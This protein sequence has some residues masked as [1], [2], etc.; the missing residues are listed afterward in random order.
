M[1]TPRLII[2]PQKI[3]TK[4][5]WDCSG[6][7]HD[8]VLAFRHLAVVQLL[9]Q[10]FLVKQSCSSPWHT[11]PSSQHREGVSWSSQ[12]PAT[13]SCSKSPTAGT[14]KLFIK[15]LEVPTGK[16]WPRRAIPVLLPEHL[17]SRA[18]MLKLKL[19]QLPLLP[20]AQFNSIA[21]AFSTMSTVPY[22][23]SSLYFT[24]SPPKKAEALNKAE[25]GDPH[26]NPS[27]LITDICKWATAKQWLSWK[28][29]KAEFFPLFSFCCLTSPK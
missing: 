13:R 6:T 10:A 1:V 22:F 27:T 3:K 24:F 26:K 11:L 14:S 21:I 4:P 19:S 12:T 2:S 28:P 15:S 7:P 29:Q 23:S 17:Q 18:L 8:L 25:P 20:L 9:C 5:G 16:Q